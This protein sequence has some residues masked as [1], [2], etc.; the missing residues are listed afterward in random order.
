MAHFV[1]HVMLAEPRLLAQKD[2]APVC[3]VRKDKY[4]NGRILVANIH[5]LLAKGDRLDDFYI[6]SGSPKGS[7]V[8]QLENMLVEQ[9]IPCY[10]S[11]MDH[12]E[13]DNRTMEGKVVFATFHAVKGRQRKHVFV[14]GFNESYF[15]YYAR[16]L[17]TD[18]CPNT[19][20]VACTRATDSLY[21][22]ENSEE[23]GP[24]PFLKMS[25]STM[26]KPEIGYVQFQ[27][28][29]Q[30][31]KRV[32]KE[33]KEIQ[34]WSTTPTELLKFLSESALDTISPIV[35][36]M[37]IRM[38][39]ITGL[40]HVDQT[41][42]VQYLEIPIPG[43]IE[44]KTHFEDVSDINGI[45]MPIL[46]YERFDKKN[47]T[48]LQELVR[49][50]MNDI[51]LTKHSFLHEKVAQMPSL[52][53]ERED[54]LFAANVCIST[55]EKLYSKLKQ[56]D[57]YDWL[58]EEIVEQ[59][60]ERF[61]GVLGNICRTESWVAEKTIIHQSADL[62]HLNIDRFFEEHLPGR[63]YRF[64]A[65][66]DF[67]TKNALWEMKCTTN[68]TIEHKLQLV[69]YM[70]L[71]HMVDGQSKP[72]FLFNVKTGEWLQ[73]IDSMED[74]SSIMLAIIKDKYKETVPKSDAEFLEEMCSA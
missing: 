2:G 6:L 64:T 18:V 57:K 58:T 28:L 33:S 61:E 34:K 35:D 55:Q 32:K 62:D 68:I 37:F 22:F 15:T 20:Y 63:K 65:R 1:N 74:L 17:P 12:Q 42:E 69:I 23:D 51:P 44:T 13:L 29:S 43:I 11:T 19:L 4:T 8:K 31:L 70:W 66:V 39:P 72:G 54:Y 3:Y 25:H 26:L 41:S 27:G 46:F 9:N 52:C 48:L 16:S 73:M 24:L 45:V 36:K 53:V 60:M 71:H 49:T 59:C 14:L 47:A 56:I 67:M 50:H 10:L 21:V 5:K 40:P 38:N 30:G 7:F